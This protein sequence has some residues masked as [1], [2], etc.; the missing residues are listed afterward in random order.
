MTITFWLNHLYNI[1]NQY[2]SAAES[3]WETIA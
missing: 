3:N 1:K 2:Q